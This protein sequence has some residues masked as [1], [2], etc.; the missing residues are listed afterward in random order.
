MAPQGKENVSIVVAFSPDLVKR[1]LNAGK[2]VAQV[3]TILG[4]KGGGRPDIASAG[5]KDASEAKLTEA[6]RIFEDIVEKSTV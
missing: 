1:G 3:A 5:G 4:G 2:V 6:R